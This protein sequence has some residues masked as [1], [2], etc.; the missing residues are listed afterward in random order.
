MSFSFA[1]VSVDDVGA[2]AVVFRDTVNSGLVPVWQAIGAYA[3]LYESQGQ[4]ARS[5]SR[6][7]AFALDRLQEDAS[8][9]ALAPPSQRG[10]PGEAIR[11]LENVLRACIIHADSQIESS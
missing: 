6:T 3:A 11:F 8:L 5:V 1:L 2:P 9:V 4:E 10:S 7:L